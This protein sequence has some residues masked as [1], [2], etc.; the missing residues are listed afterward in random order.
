MLLNEEIAK[1]SSNTLL[2]TS[3]RG[4]PKR[5]ND[6][7]APM[8][9][10]TADCLEELWAWGFLSASVVQVISSAVMADGLHNE[11]LK[12]FAR[13]GTAGLHV[14]NACRD[15]MRATGKAGEQFPAAQV[16]LPIQCKRD[17]IIKKKIFSIYHQVIQFCLMH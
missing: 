3:V 15:L 1:T 16:L 10:A 13:I 9:N 4:R 14:G 5:V 12:R 7:E 6:E 2:K 8:T 17:K 11:K